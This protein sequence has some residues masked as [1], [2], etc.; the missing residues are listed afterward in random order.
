[1]FAQSYDPFGFDHPQSPRASERRKRKEYIRR[2]LMVKTER[3]RQ[4][5]MDQMQL[6]EDKL[7]MQERQ[8]QMEIRQWELVDDDVYEEEELR[9]RRLG[10][11]ASKNN[12]VS[13]SQA[14]AILLPNSFF[15]PLPNLAS[16]IHHSELEDSATHPP[17]TIVLKHSM[18]DIP[19]RKDGKQ[20][21]RHTDPGICPV[22]IK[23][24]DD[25]AR[26]EDMILK[27]QQARN[28]DIDEDD[29]T[30]TL[31]IIA[32]EDISDDE[33]EDDED[34]NSIWKAGFILPNASFP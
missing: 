4:A 10:L 20:C 16:S 22:H 28:G 7:Q 19:P 11:V 26:I 12:I 2:Q 31:H 33:D 3:R 5:E 8:R 1:M 15:P 17:K 14:E 13:D 30:E 34:L 18:Q 9:Q 23:D 25:Q 32:E 21:R 29:A 24:S 6:I 27:E